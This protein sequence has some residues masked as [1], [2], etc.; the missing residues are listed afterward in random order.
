MSIIIKGEKLP[1]N[2]VHCWYIA[3]CKIF[4]RWIPMEDT[5][6]MT[7]VVNERLEHCPMKEVEE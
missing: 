5:E 1:P 3:R 6:T 7:K 2:C 4:P